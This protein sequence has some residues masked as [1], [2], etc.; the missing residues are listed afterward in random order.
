LDPRR[1]TSPIVAS[2]SLLPAVTL[3]SQVIFARF[4]GFLGLF[5]ALPLMVVTQVWVKELLVKDVFNKWQRDGSDKPQSASATNEDS[6][7]N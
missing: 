1:I 2:L 5:L 6:L 7:V 4:F 3:A